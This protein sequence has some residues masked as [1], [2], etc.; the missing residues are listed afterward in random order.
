M[1]GLWSLETGR[2]AQYYAAHVESRYR[3]H[4]GTSVVLDPLRGWQWTGAGPVPDVV[5]LVD[6]LAGI[7]SVGQLSSWRNQVLAAHQRLL[8][9]LMRRVNSEDLYALT[10]R[11]LVELHE[12]SAPIGSRDMARHLGVPVATLH[13]Y[14]AHGQTPPGIVELG[15]SWGWTRPQMERW[16]ANRLARRRKRS[17]SKDPVPSVPVED[18]GQER[19]E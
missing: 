17:I 5:S 1:D 4:P 2:K 7:T 12:V 3:D 19:K 9:E 16:G 11:L 8:R 13:A 15:T 18:P 14:R 6:V 10:D